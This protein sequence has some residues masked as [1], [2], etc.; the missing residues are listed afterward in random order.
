MLILTRRF[1][2]SIIIND[3]IEI[4]V[5][6]RKEGQIRIGIKAPKEVPVYRKEIHEKIKLDELKKQE[7]ENDK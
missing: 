6:S 2:E 5:M 7:E 3:N 1:G 4:V